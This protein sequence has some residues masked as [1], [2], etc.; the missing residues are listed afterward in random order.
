MRGA[1]RRPFCL[2]GEAQ[3]ADGR[4]R[5]R[6]AGEGELRGVVGARGW[7]CR[8]LDL[9]VRTVRSVSAME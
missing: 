1:E 5:G 4:R 2:S 3:G 8:P 9:L 7:R 6:D